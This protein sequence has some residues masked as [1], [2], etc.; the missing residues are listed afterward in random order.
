MADTQTTVNTIDIQLLDADRGDATTIKLDNPKNGMTRES[1]SSAMQAPLANGWFLT[2]KG[3]VAMYLGDITLNTSIKTKLGGEDF[4]VTPSTITMVVPI[5]SSAE[6]T[7]T[8][9]GA[10][11][12]GFNFANITNNDPTY[13]ARVAD[14]GL[15]VTLK[16]KQNTG[17]TQGTFDFILIIQGTRVVIPVSFDDH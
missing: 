4:Y 1:V 11:I 9:T 10:T 13:T 16:I 2:N 14:N 7:V 17:D 6:S 8:V 5:N 3:A 12:Q 15:S